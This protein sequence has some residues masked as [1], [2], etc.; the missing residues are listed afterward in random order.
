[1][2]SEN[3]WRDA[4]SDAVREAIYGHMIAKNFI[5]KY[6]SS[7]DGV[8]LNT[9]FNAFAF[10][11][12]NPELEKAA[13]DRVV[14]FVEMSQY[15]GTWLY[16]K[17]AAVTAQDVFGPLA[18]LGGWR[19]NMVTNALGG[20]STLTAGL[21]SGL[22]GAGLGYG[23]GWVG[24]KLMDEQ[25][26]KRKGRLSRMGSIL[27]G[28]GGALPALWAGHRGWFK[29]P[30]NLAQQAYE[31]GP[32]PKPAPLQPTENPR[33]P[34]PP[35]QKYASSV[36]TSVLSLLEREVPGQTARCKAAALGSQGFDTVI[37]VDHFNRSI[38]EDSHTPMNIRAAAGGILEGSSTLRGGENMVSPADVARIGVGIGTG[39]KM[40]MVV[41]KTFAS[42]AGLSKSAQNKLQETGVWAGLL[43]NIVPLMFGCRP[44]EL[45]G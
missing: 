21:G 16:V 40:G 24:D 10:E 31:E 8:Y 23:L 5:D 20:P 37:P 4:A 14:R 36:L 9:R 1:M 30:D 35:G 13:N 22:L 44:T 29:D 28:V 11:E 32:L 39:Y 15:P 12:P 7:P 41:G 26:P 33:P 42:L 6:G 3:V 25:D 17:Q 2:Y 34:L 45:H 19:H 43:N 18:H 27:G 38:W